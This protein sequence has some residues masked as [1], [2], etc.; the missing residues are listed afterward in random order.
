MSLN[1]AKNE[2]NEFLELRKKYINNRKENKI[3][4]SILEVDEKISSSLQDSIKIEKRKK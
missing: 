2:D 3:L 4:S 1:C